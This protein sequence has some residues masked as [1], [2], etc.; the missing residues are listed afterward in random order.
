MLDSY[1]TQPSTT[2]IASA[3][4]PRIVDRRTDQ[5][6]TAILRLALMSS[7]DEVQL[8]RITNA[9]RYGL[10]ATAFRPFPVGSSVTLRVPDS[11]TLFGSIVW[12][13]A[14]SVGIQLDEPL[15]NPLL[16][17][18]DDKQSGAKARRR[19]PRIPVE[20]FATLD[21]GAK[22]C[23]VA[24]LDVSPRGAMVSGAQELPGPGPVQLEAPGLPKI[25]AQVRWRHGS[26]A[27][28][29]FNAPITLD[30]FTAWFERHCAGPSHSARTLQPLAQ[31]A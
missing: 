29:L 18:F 11:T 8:C 19:L 20:M 31:T 28:L 22:K 1:A 15:P 5:R 3:P 27:G 17:R 30:F 4:A 21:S 23:R 6:C 9:S 16:L 13:R 24:V 10:Q 14:R 25:G 26:R 7:G 12:Q 2:P